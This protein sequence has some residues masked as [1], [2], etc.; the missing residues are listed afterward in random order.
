MTFRYQRPLVFWVLKD[1]YEFIKQRRAE[2][3]LGRFSLQQGYRGVI[4]LERGVFLCIF[5]EALM[6][7]LFFNFYLLATPCMAC[8]ILVPQPGIEPMSPAVET[9]SLNHWTAREVPKDTDGLFYFMFWFKA[10]RSFYLTV[11]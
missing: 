4:L 1:E 5:H 9:Q 8:G 7:Y 6:I 3:R 11:L 2:G 10:I